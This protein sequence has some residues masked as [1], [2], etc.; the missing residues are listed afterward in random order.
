MGRRKSGNLAETGGRHR[1][2]IR[3]KLVR[4]RKQETRQNPVNARSSGVR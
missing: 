4:R 2:E 3:Q 1:Q